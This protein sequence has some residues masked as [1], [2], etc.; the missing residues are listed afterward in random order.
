MTVVYLPFTVIFSHATSHLIHSVS[1]PASVIS[2]KAWCFFVSWHNM[3]PF[4]YG[5]WWWSGA[6][7][8]CWC[9]TEVWPHSGGHH[10]IFAKKGGLKN[11]I[12]Y[13]LFSVFSNLYANNVYCSQPQCYWCIINVTCCLFYRHLQVSV[14]LPKWELV[15]Q[16]SRQPI[17]Q[18]VL[19]I[20][21]PQR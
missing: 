1:K 4:M 11:E 15:R 9:N 2:E 3:L 18:R 14:K 21:Y 6:G 12:L 20:S 5:D 16:E 17:G 13:L 8:D 19:F 7:I 10:S